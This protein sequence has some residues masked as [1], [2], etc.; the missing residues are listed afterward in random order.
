MA[1]RVGCL[2][3]R[4]LPLTHAPGILGQVTSTL[5]AVVL[6]SRKGAHN[7]MLFLNGKAQKM[8]L[9]ESSMKVGCQHLGLG[10]LL[11]VPGPVQRTGLAWVHPSP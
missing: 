9:R 7:S 8:V 5:P 1:G 3:S 10:L 6:L 2:Q 4:P 11:W